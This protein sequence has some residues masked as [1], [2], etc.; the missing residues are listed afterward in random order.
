MGASGSQHET[1]GNENAA[2]VILIQ[3]C[4]GWGYYR[5]AST[6]AERIEAKYPGLFKIV[7]AQDSGAT[8]RLEVTIFFNQKEPSDKGGVLFHSKKNGQGFPHTNWVDFEKRL[9]D[10]VSA[11]GVQWERNLSST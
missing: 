3:Y 11:A 1:R 6:A 4:G 8:G 7:L 9:T 5:P 2:H 10:A